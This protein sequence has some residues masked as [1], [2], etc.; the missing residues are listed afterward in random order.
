[1]V[2][3]ED[4]CNNGYAIDILKQIFFLDKLRYHQADNNKLVNISLF[5]LNLR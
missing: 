5:S 2:L 3:M 1:M 4:F